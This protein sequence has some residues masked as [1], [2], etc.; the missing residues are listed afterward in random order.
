MALLNATYLEKYSGTWKWIDNTGEITKTTT[1]S[2]TSVSHVVWGQD[3]SYFFTSSTTSTGRIEKWARDG[4][5]YSWRKTGIDTYFAGGIYIVPDSNNNLYCGKNDDIYLLGESDGVIDYSN[6]GSDLSGYTVYGLAVDSSDNLYVLAQKDDYS[7]NRVFKFS[8]TLSLTTSFQVYN[9]YAG[10][11]YAG[12]N[13]I[14]VDSSGNI[15]V[16]QA[17]ILYKFNSSGTQ[18]WAYTDQTI[19]DIRLANSKIYG[20]SGGGYYRVFKL[21]DNGSSYTEEWNVDV[22]DDDLYPS[23]IAVTSDEVYCLSG[24]ASWDIGCLDESD[25]S[26]L[27]GFTPIDVSNGIVACGIDPL[28]SITCGFLSTTEE[29]QFNRWVKTEGYEIVGAFELSEQIRCKGYGNKLIDKLYLDGNYQHSGTRYVNVAMVGDPPSEEFAIQAYTFQTATFNVVVDPDYN[30]YVKCYR[31][32]DASQAEE[33]SDGYYTSGGSYWSIKKYNS[34]GVEQWETKIVIGTLVDITI[35]SDFEYIYGASNY[36]NKSVFR[37]DIETGI[38][39]T[40]GNFPLT[41]LL[42]T[43]DDFVTKTFKFGRD[44]KLYFVIKDYSDSNYHYLHKFNKD[45]TRAT[46]WSSPLHIVGENEPYD[47]WRIQFLDVNADGYIGLAGTSDISD[48]TP[49]KI[50]APNKTLYKEYLLP[51]SE[52]GSTYCLIDDNEAI[53]CNGYDGSN[54]GYNIFKIPVSGTNKYDY[55]ITWQFDYNNTT[56]EYTFYDPFWSEADYPDYFYAYASGVT[57]TF[58][59]WKYKASDGSSVYALP[60]DYETLYSWAGVAP[61]PVPAWGITVTFGSNGVVTTYMNDDGGGVELTSGDVVYAEAGKDCTFL[62]VGDTGYYVDTVTVDSNNIGYRSQYTFENVLNNHTIH[63]TFGEGFPSGPFVV[64]HSITGGVLATQVAGHFSTSY[65]PTL[66]KLNWYFGAGPLQETLAITGVGYLPFDVSLL[67]LIN[68]YRSS[69][70]VD[71]VID[72]PT[73]W[74]IDG[75]EYAVTDMIANGGSLTKTLTQIMGQDGANYPYLYAAGIPTKAGTS[76]T[77][78]DIFDLWVADGPTEAVILSSNYT[79]ISIYVE[80]YSGDNYIFAL[81]AQWHPQYTV[82]RLD[83]NFNLENSIRVFDPFYFLSSELHEQILEI[84]NE[85]GIHLQ[86][87]AAYIG[88]YEIPNVI[89][90][91]Y[92]LISN[93][94]SYLSITAALSNDVFDEIYALMDEQIRIESIVNFKGEEIRD[95]VIDVEFQN[96]SAEDAASP[97]ISYDEDQGAITLSGYKWLNYYQT[98]VN[99]RN[100]ISITKYSGGEKNGEIM[101][102]CSQPD[103]YLRPGCTVHYGN[104]SADVIKVESFV[105]DGVNQYMNVTGRLNG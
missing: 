14:A 51:D 95:T 26:V 71:S 101:F 52:Y 79:E 75:A 2:D 58:N 105:G 68:A 9:G 78:D 21:T 64:N 43:L 56:G 93:K 28:T 72:D 88:D 98:D 6:V 30:V 86:K 82:E 99:L 76:F 66:S 50:I 40:D 100:V 90:F 53:I 55:T 1:L 103:F 102:K 33:A 25:G 104:Y 59:L 73:G 11:S 5:T 81:F 67:Y 24:S 23:M 49:I 47:D 4:T 22:N 27:T 41:T 97:I 16:G 37:Y 29:I 46:N 65:T 20:C 17:N 70:G 94:V 10:L 39:E 89:T 61:L 69:N 84:A 32:Y 60:A 83:E 62:F 7:E 8:T 3:G 34:L 15:F 85:R 35:D 13:I 48:D 36:L 38:E 42:S 45:G 92:R 87:Y 12:G 19:Y 57:T 63:V 54:G 91:N 74:L 31:S 77:P 18:Q 44:G 96:L 80:E